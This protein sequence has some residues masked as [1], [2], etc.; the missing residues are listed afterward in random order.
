MK[1]RKISRERKEREKFKKLMQPAFDQMD[2]MIDDLSYYVADETAVVTF[3][4]A[5]RKEL[6]AY[7][8]NDILRSFSIWQSMDGELTHDS[9]ALVRYRIHC[10]LS[11]RG[12]DEFEYHCPSPKFRHALS[13]WMHDRNR[14]RLKKRESEK[15]HLEGFKNICNDQY[16]RSADDKLNRLNE[17]LDNYL[18]DE[19]HGPKVSFAAIVNGK[20]YSSDDEAA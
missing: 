19:D 20:V 7:V 13:D 14:T 5:Y 6:K 10:A 3:L 12:T 2:Q 8:K 4:K 18:S 9:Y 11:T 16:L 15:I 17:V 1:R